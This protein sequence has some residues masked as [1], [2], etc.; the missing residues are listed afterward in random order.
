MPLSTYTISPATLTSAALST[1]YASS[2]GVMAGTGGPFD[3]LANGGIS[4]RVRINGGAWQ[5]ADL[6]GD[7]SVSIGDLVEIKH[8]TG[9]A[10]NTTVTSS[11]F[12]DGQTKTWA[13]TTIARDVT[14]NGVAFTDVTGAA[15]S[16][17]YTSNT[18]TISGINDGIIIDATGGEVSVN[19]GAWGA[20]ASAVNG[21]TF[22]LRR[23]SSG[24]NGTAVT[25]DATAR[26][27][28]T[29]LD[30]F[31][32]T[33][34][35]VDT[36]PDAFTFTDQSG[37]VVSTLTTSNTITIA[38]VAAPAN[39]SFSTSGT[40]TG[41]QCQKN[42]LGWVT[43]TGTP[44]TVSNGDTVQLRLTSAPS[45]GGVGN[46]VV[47]IGSPATTDTW[48]VTAAVADTT[49]DAFT[50]TDLGA[51]AINTVGTSNVVTITGIDGTANVSFSNTNGTSHEYRKNGGAWTAIGATTCVVND[52]FQVRH[53]VGGTVAIGSSTTMTVGGVSD[54]FNCTS[55]AADTTPDAFS[56]V[57]ITGAQLS[58]LTASAGVTVAGISAAAAISI[59]GADAQYSINGG[60]Y[61]STAG[62]VVNGDVVTVRLTSAAQYVT[63]INAVLTIGGVSDTFSVT[64][65]SPSTA[66]QY[67]RTFRETAYGVAP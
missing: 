40:A 22:Q 42:A 5:P 44:F 8:N 60:A 29:F 30:Q 32:I 53:T 41:F 10:F 47:T 18:Q 57:D 19:G 15:L 63:Q 25:V 45:S 26:E 9:G 34:V 50:F 59:S 14:P 43:A 46:V 6:P 39:A 52:T 21:D 64:T 12:I 55:A 56:F 65:R 17:L 37:V 35:A 31:V 28:S 27:T 49:P 16:T 51:V 11:L 4:T 13:T 38:G 7:V 23:T 66:K 3:L 33:T 1:D 62:T 61:T 2:A 24:S 20:S 58:T 67:V 48:T 36:T 54:A